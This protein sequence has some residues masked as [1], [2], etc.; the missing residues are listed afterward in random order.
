M[1]KYRE[2]SKKPR[3][4]YRLTELT[5]VSYKNIFYKILSVWIILV[6]PRNRKILMIQFFRE[7]IT[8]GALRVRIEERSSWKVTSRT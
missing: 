8:R 1:L 4:L 2:I 6:F 7:A 5:L 3:I